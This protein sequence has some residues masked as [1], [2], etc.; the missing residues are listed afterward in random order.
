[1]GG[2]PHLRPAVH[3]CRRRRIG[4]ALADDPVLNHLAALKVEHD[5]GLAD[6][7]DAVAPGGDDLGIPRT[8]SAATPPNS[9]L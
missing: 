5:D 6:V 8:S 1:M 4:L 3:P 7:D 2:G 9:R